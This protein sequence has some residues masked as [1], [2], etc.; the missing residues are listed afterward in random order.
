MKGEEAETLGSEK[1]GQTD[2]LK[3]VTSE[4]ET[5]H[6]PVIGADP[7]SKAVWV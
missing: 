3:I 2:V 1:E 7:L 4:V 6:Q 5:P